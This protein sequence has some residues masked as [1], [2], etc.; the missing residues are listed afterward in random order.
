M[1]F[2]LEICWI[3]GIDFEHVLDAVQAVVFAAACWAERKLLLGN[4]LDIFA[5][6]W[7]KLAFQICGTDQLPAT[8]FAEA[9]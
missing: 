5:D 1:E 8:V 3:H 9:S 7:Q 2:L 4:K 6:S